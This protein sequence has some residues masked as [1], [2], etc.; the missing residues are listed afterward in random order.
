MSGKILLFAIS[1]FLMT[2]ASQARQSLTIVTNNYPPYITAD[3]NSSFLGDLFHEIGA[4]IGIDFEFQFY[5]WKRGEQAVAEGKAW[6]TIPY[7]KSESREKKFLFSDA[8]YLADSHFFAYSADGTKPPITFNDLTDLRPYRIGGIQGYYYEPWFE[9]AGLDVQY[10][11]SEEQNFQL[12]QRGRI[13]LFTTATTMGWYV[14]ENLFPPEE[15]AKFYTLDKPLVAG[16]GLFLMTSKNYPQTR[17]L[18]EKFNRGLH[19]IKTDG[20]YTR[21][22]HKHGLI[23]TY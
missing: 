12:L 16:E 6:G 10:S 22:V 1:L 8:L 15:V 18:L 19:E 23:M 14:I 5:P 21:L 13:D 9:N 17:I 20:T 11:H 4:R 2:A 3:R 7:R